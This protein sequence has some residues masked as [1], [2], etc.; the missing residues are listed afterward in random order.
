MRRTNHNP[1]AEFAHLFP[2]REFRSRGSLGF[3]HLPYIVRPIIEHIHETKPDIV[4]AGDR[5]GRFFAV[6]AMKS[7]A[8]RYPEHHFP[9]ASGKIHM[10]RV[11]KRS[12]SG[13]E[14]AE[15]T[16]WTLQQAGIDEIRKKAEQDGK[17]PS[18]LYMDDWAV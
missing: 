11:T 13:G 1:S 2:D 15:A 7:W 10:A 9:T 17:A 8:H 4:V 14:V 5:G 18:V 16:R 12:A 3:R 6:T